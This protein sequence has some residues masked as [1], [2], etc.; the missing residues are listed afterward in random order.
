MYLPDALCDDYATIMRRLNEYPMPYPK[1]KEKQGWFVIKFVNP[2][3]REIPRINEFGLNER[4]KKA[5]EYLC[6]H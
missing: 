4:Q 5:I 1:F 3:V 2:L 6:S